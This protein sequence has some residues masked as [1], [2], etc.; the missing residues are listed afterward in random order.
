MNKIKNNNILM[1]IYLIHIIKLKIYYT[2]LILL[3]YLEK[4]YNY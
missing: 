4:L 3:I 1:N 2:K